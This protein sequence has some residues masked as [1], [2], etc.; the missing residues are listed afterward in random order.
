M[1]TLEKPTR[2]M[3][4][5]VLGCKSKARVCLVQSLICSFA[6]LVL[7]SNLAA[8]S[9]FRK[10]EPPKKKSAV[11]AISAFHKKVKKSLF[12]R[13][14]SAPPRE[15]EQN[16]RADPYPPRQPPNY[17]GPEN[18]P[19]AYAPNSG[20]DS[21]DSRANNR[22]N[23]R[24]NSQPYPRRVSKVQY[25]EPVQYGHPQ[26][27]ENYPTYDE[28]RSRQPVQYDQHSEPDYRGY[29]SP[30]PSGTIQ[31]RE[32][33]PLETHD[34]P[35]E[36]R[37]PDLQRYEVAASPPPVVSLNDSVNPNGNTQ[38]SVST[39]SP[40]STQPP[41]SPDYRTGHYQNEGVSQI[42]FDQQI[43]A[44]QRVIKLRDQN[45]QLRD[46][47][48]SLAADN[49]RVQKL[50]REKEALLQEVSV[51][52]E[53]A[54]GE[55]QLATQENTEMKK[56]IAKLESENVKQTNT[57]SK[58]LDDIRRKLDDVLMQEITNK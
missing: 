52:I 7:S 4:I 46:A 10:L 22:A 12:G 13:V 33:L 11:D 53:S 47:Y 1:N 38:D 25:Q 28:T 2:E 36:S 37:G 49:Q 56:H 3:G 29:Q 40:S 58:Q 9:D 21:A 23:T 54:R 48:Q 31:H 24:N 20:Y 8:Q 30:P 50:L 5:P 19:R 39:P 15:F 14:D 34:R 44:T 6:V 55:L 18:R 35:P 51:A 57:A 16:Q 43:T 17:A 27:Q 32:L 26:H 41:A 45:Q 42:Q